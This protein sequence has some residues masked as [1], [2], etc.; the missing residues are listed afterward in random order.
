MMNKYEDLLKELGID[1]CVIA[2]RK[3]PLSEV[4]TN[5]K[6]NVHFADEAIN[7]I[8]RQTKETGSCSAIAMDISGFFDNLNHTLIKRQWLRVMKFE[9]GMPHHHFTIFKNITRFKYITSDMLEG[10]LAVKFRKL[11]HDKVKQ[12]CTPDVFKKKVLPY[13]SEQNKVGIPQGTTISDVIANMYMI[14]FDVLMTKFAKKYSGYYRRYSDDILIILPTKYQVKAMK[15]VPWLVRFITK[16]KISPKKTLVSQFKT[17][18]NET[19]CTTF[20]NID[21]QLQVVGK[22]FEYLGL[23]FDGK[24]KQ[25]RQSTLSGFHDRLSGR[26]KVEA[27]IAYQKLKKTWCQTPYRC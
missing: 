8:K 1:E 10:K 5:G 9:T 17:A 13:V 12:I 25:I 18:S 11:H 6:C 3:I 26:I 22:P 24:T 4:V 14:D 19:Q 7:E 27:E 15:F 16:L 2:Y 20:K 23:S 21:G